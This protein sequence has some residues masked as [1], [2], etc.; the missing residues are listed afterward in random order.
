VAMSDKRAEVIAGL[1]EM[2]RRLTDPAMAHKGTQVRIV[3]DDGTVFDGV[4]TEVA[5]DGTLTIIRAD[6]WPVSDVL[7]RLYDHATEEEPSWLKD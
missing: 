4:V 1:A 2:G 6:A 7:K 5:P 3:F